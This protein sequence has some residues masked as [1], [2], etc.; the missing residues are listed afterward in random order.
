M[1]SRSSTESRWLPLWMVA[2]GILALLGSG[3][4]CEQ[5]DYLQQQVV[6]L[7][8]AKVLESQAIVLAHP[9][10][11]VNTIDYSLTNT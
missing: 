9:Y 1:P 6:S 2:L 4:T 3:A 8:S 11:G 5:Q 10:R 7:D